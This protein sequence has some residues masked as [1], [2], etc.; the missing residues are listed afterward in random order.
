[1]LQQ[2]LIQG[3]SGSTSPDRHRISG[4]AAARGATQNRRTRSGSSSRTRIIRSIWICYRVGPEKVPV[5]TLLTMHGCPS[6]PTISLLHQLNPLT[7][8]AEGREVRRG[9]RPFHSRSRLGGHGWSFRAAQGTYL[10]GSA[11]EWIIRS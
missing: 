2:S 7:Q 5:F 3:M 11:F 8:T 1:M 10:R 6:A 4:P 9:L